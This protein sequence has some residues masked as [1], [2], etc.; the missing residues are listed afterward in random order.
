MAGRIEDYAIIGNTR[1]VALVDR[2]GSVDWWCVPRIDS[3]AVFAALLEPKPTG[4][5]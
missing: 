1:T 2:S 5:G 3:G 4:A